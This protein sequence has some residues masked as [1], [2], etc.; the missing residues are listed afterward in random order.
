MNS[1]QGAPSPAGSNIGGTGAG[2]PLWT[3]YYNAALQNVGAGSCRYFALVQKMLI[4]K[5][6]YVPLVSPSYDV[7]YRKS[8]IVGAPPTW[9]PDAFGFPWFHVKAK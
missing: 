1:L 3:R 5:Q 8:K 2:D 4:Q 9:P 6:Y 7:F